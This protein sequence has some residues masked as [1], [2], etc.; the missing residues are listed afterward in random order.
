MKKHV[1]LVVMGLAACSSSDDSEE[2]ITV[3][4]EA[5]AAGSVPVDVRHDAGTDTL[6]YSIGGSD[7]ATLSRDVTLDRDSFEG[8]QDAAEGHYGYRVVSASGN[9][10]VSVGAA[11]DT[12]NILSVNY[13][14]VNSTALPVSGS[15]TYN[16][17][18]LGLI[19]ASGSTDLRSV[20]TGDMSLTANFGTSSVSGS[21]TNRVVGTIDTFAANGE[22]TTD[23]VLDAS[24]I[25]DIGGFSGDAFGATF[26]TDSGANGYTLTSGQYTGLISG[27]TANET[28]GGVFIEYTRTTGAGGPTGL[29]ETGAFL[30]TN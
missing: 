18:Y 3:E 26:T 25:D 20:V 13:E 14:R 4:R 22:V 16:G 1:L 27:G 5:V 17:D 30:A 29:V 9:S 15:T 7:I 6:I 12:F 24:G 21:V 10:I 28:V 19:T 11:E 23:L 2:T 8:F